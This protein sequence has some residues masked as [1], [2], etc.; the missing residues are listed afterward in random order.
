VDQDIACRDC[1]DRFLF[2]VAEQEF[3]ASKGM[4]PPKRCKPCRRT[5]KQ[6]GE[7]AS[8]PSFPELRAS[9]PELR[10]SS[11]ELPPSSSQDVLPSARDSRPSR[12]RMDRP[13]FDIVCSECGAAAQVPFKPLEGR[14]VFCP[15]C[16]RA[17]K[18]SERLATDG[19]DVT[20]ADLGIVE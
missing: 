7:R 3:Y 8:R 19:L 20:D 9:S 6:Q 11:G 2:T 13:R 17:K 14:Q 10:T 18:G 16:Y 4:K 1:G 12:P 5:R 15:T